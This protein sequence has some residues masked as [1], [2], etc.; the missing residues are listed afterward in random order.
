MAADL[1]QLTMVGW[2]AVNCSGESS[3]LPPHLLR[4]TC[5]R[6]RAC[7]VRAKG[8]RSLRALATSDLLVATNV[9]E[10]DDGGVNNHQLL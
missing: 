5:V 7:G 10:I 1:L 6:P 2:T 3:R 8:C 4:V 9:V